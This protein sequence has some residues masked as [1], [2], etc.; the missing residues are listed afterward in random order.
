[1]KV[2]K[3]CIYI[4]TLLIPNWYK[5]EQPDGLQHN[6]RQILKWKFSCGSM[7][8]RVVMFSVLGSSFP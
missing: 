6:A 1:M 8:V 7:A 3:N 4:Y 5:V 2:A